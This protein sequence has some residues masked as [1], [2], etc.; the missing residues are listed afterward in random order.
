MSSVVSNPV[1]TGL[2]VVDLRSDPAFA[3]RHLH[4]RD[5]ATQIAGIL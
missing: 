1:D 3:K 2:E 4:T 5:V